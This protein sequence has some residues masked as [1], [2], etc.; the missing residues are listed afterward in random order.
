MTAAPPV[1]RPR[2]DP[3]AAAAPRPKP[4]RRHWGQVLRKSSIPYL[5]LLPSG[6]IFLTFSLIPIFAA[7][8]FSFNSGAIAVNP[9]F[10]G[11][12]NYQR[13]VQDELFWT[14]LRNTAVFTV[15]TVPTSMA[16]GLL[17]AVLLNRPMPGRVVLRTIFFAPMVAS[18]VGVAVVMSWIFNYDYGVVDNGI[19]A[20]GGARIPWLTSPDMAMLTVVLAVLWSRIGFCMVLYLAALQAVPE[21]LIEAATLDG[22]SAWKRFRYVTWP[23]IAPTTF[24]LLIINV[25]FSLQ[26][27]DLLFVLTGGGPGFATTVLVQYIFRAAFSNGDMGYASA[28]GVVFTL[29]LVAFT[30]LRYRSSKKSEDVV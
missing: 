30:L 4:P 19:A 10:V 22:A 24:F 20:L 3:D 29:I 1:A 14:A 15:G 8:W 25:V 27:F 9:R 7:F 11:V 17:L 12:E 2:L 23:L 16:G 21:S 18:G 5:F 13:I 6:A 26:V 28:I